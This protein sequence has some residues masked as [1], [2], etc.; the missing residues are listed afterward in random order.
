M[1]TFVRDVTNSP[2]VINNLKDKESKLSYIS[3]DLLTIRNVSPEGV[4]T[5]IKEEM[6]RQF[7]KE[8]WEEWEN[9]LSRSS[10]KERMDEV[11]VAFEKFLKDDKPGYN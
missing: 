11:S 6:L 5:D 8:E 10:L 3:D 4:I 1:A 7:S 2:A 9:R